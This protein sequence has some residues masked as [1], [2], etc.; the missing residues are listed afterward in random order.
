LPVEDVGEE[1]ALG[2][3]L[4]PL[5]RSACDA[6]FGAEFEVHG[7]PKDLDGARALA[8][9]DK[10]QF[11]WWA[12]SLVDAI[13]YGGKKKGADS[14]ID[15]FIYFKPEA[16]E[17]EKAIVSAKGGEHITVAMIRDL[18]HVVDRERPTSASSS[19]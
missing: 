1:L 6:F 16:K 8:A 10:Y 2:R 15:G 17:T 7:T 19:L 14:G 12:V 11:Q 5:S 3:Q 13:A 18:A 9:Q 4:F